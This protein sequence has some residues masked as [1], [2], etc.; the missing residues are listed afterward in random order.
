MLVRINTI[1]LISTVPGTVLHKEKQKARYTTE[2]CK[3]YRIYNALINLCTSVW[4]GYFNTTTVCG[5]LR[6][7]SGL[8]CNQTVRV[9]VELPAYPDTVAALGFYTIILLQ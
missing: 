7:L 6:L 2:L 1:H 8:H 5:T 3:H 9:L 4:S